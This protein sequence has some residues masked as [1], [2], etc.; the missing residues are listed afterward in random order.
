MIW[1]LAFLILARFLYRLKPVRLKDIKREYYLVKKHFHIEKDLP[2][3][4][5][6]DGNYIGDCKVVNLIFC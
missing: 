5:H 3:H 1:L 4:A 2:I 6:L